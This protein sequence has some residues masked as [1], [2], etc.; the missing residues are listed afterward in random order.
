M[1]L[2]AMRMNI[3]GWYQDKL[4]RQGVNLQGIEEVTAGKRDTQM[5][6]KQRLHLKHYY[7]FNVG[8]TAMQNDIQH[9]LYCDI[10]WTSNTQ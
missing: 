5:A 10:W 9:I 6:K 3:T 1:V 7:N 8:A 2:G 4:L